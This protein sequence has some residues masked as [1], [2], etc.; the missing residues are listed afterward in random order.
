MGTNRRLMLGAGVG[1]ALV[2]IL[3]HVGPGLAKKQHKK[4]NKHCKKNKK[5]CD[6]DCA[7][8]NTDVNQCKNDCQIAKKQCK[9][10][11]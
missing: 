1:L 10:T 7:W 9:K 5:Q 3:G 6:R 8:L 2:E 11:C 4:C